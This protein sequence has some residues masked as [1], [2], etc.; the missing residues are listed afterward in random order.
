M[1]MDLRSMALQGLSAAGGVALALV[2]VS[3]LR[4]DP[5]PFLPGSAPEGYLTA[6]TEDYV[7]HAP[8]AEAMRLGEEDLRYAARMFRHH[9]GAEPRKV[10]V[11]LA[12]SPAAFATMNLRKLRRPGAGFLPFLSHRFLASTAPDEGALAL[13]GGAVLK[14]VDGAPR[15]V[16]IVDAGEPAGP[17]L[18][19]GDVIAA[20]N[21][22]PAGDVASLARSLGALR[23]GA[24]V[25]MDVIREGGPVR[26]AYEKG[27]SHLRAAR[28]FADSASRFIT[29]AK[30]LSHEACHNYVAGYA[31]DLPGGRRGAADAYGHAALPDWF[32]E[33]A[34]TLCESPASQ[35][36]RRAHLR[37]NLHQR[38][39][40]AELAR[41]EHPLA[42]NRLVR[43]IE[44]GDGFKGS[45]VQ[46]IGREQ[47]QRAL[48]GS[49]DAMLFYSQALSLGEFLFERGG[50]PALQALARRLN[51]GDDLDAALREAHRTSPRLPAS[52]AQLEEEWVR[53][54]TRDGTAGSPD[55]S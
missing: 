45:P 34:A 41:M 52:L 37:A 29:Q 48:R 32:D 39:P 33:M 2:V 35:A 24:A 16:S 1:K 9:F 51:A 21:G 18:R 25:E 30:T 10:V 43:V 15:V 44:L 36:R 53:W 8:S 47:L 14:D 11:F 31:E 20:M 54:V 7:L 3:L 49:P 12:D 26:V 40:L 22:A 19:V 28:I 5:L 38:I 55:R 17:D 50:T 4:G 42:A 23:T 6:G 46:V 13:D 27:T